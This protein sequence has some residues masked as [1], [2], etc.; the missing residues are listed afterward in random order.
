MGLFR[1]KFII[2]P[3]DLSLSQKNGCSCQRAQNESWRNK[4]MTEDISLA[5]KQTG[6]NLL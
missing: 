1:S 5:R 4:E 2:L 6:R 3:Y